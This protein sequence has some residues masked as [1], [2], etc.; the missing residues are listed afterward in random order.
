[1][2]G[3]ETGRPKA[4]EAAP[5]A[6][7]KAG[8]QAEREKR[9]AGELVQ[10]EAELSLMP[11]V[12]RK[13]ERS[14]RRPGHTQAPLRSGVMVLEAE[15]HSGIKTPSSSARGDSQSTL[16]R[17]NEGGPVTPHRPWQLHP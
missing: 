10:A 12:Q 8:R 7:S 5:R 11:R 2:L 16:C 14:P 3:E 17:R 4:S 6:G 9:W 13:I 15:P 1:M